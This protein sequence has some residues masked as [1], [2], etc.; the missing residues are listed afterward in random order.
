MWQD[1][2]LSSWEPCSGVRERFQSKGSPEGKVP[3]TT[4]TPRGST[5]P[6]D[7]L[8]EAPNLLLTEQ[9]L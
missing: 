1:M 8:S 2:F 5:D 6:C 3:G 4:V 7:V 9:P